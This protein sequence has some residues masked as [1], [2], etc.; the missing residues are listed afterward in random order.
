MTSLAH[1]AR[2]LLEGGKRVET[3]PND[4]IVAGTYKTKNF[5]QSSEAQKLYS[6]LPKDTVPDDAEKCAIFQ[7]KLF[8]IHKNVMATGRA[9]ESDVESAKSLENKIKDYAKSMKLEKEHGYI[10]KIVKQ[11]TDKLSVSSNIEDA[12][13]IK[14]GKI[15]DRFK[16]PSKTITKEIPDSDID[17]SR[18]VISRNLKAQR[19]IKLID[20]D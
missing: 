13:K 17:N 2:M 15:E 18:F 14:P 20:V 8:G 16:S 7:D 6:S 4:Q 1:I 19:K 3:D 11:I 5:E 9:T 10:D 12:S